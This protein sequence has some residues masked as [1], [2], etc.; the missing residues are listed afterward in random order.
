MA[1]K[2]R[3]LARSNH[4]PGLRHTVKAQNLNATAR[5]P[6]TTAKAEE[7]FKALIS[8]EE[9]AVVGHDGMINSVVV[10]EETVETSV[11]PAQF[12]KGGDNIGKVIDCLDKSEKTGI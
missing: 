5:P 3:P 1:K 6:N 2:L 9:L 10:K 4:L 7:R 11:G 8:N 12:C